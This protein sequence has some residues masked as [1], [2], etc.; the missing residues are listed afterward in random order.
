MASLRKDVSNVCVYN[1]LT[2]EEDIRLDRS[3]TF[4]SINFENMEIKISA[5]FSKVVFGNK[6]ENFILS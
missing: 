1:I 5:D 2:L 6:D 4:N 3:I